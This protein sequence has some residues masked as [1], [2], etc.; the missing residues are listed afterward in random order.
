MK[1]IL[2]VRSTIYPQIMRKT[3]FRGVFVGLLGILIIIYAG[4]AIPEKTLSVWGFPLFMLGIGLLT[5]GLIPYR[6]LTRLE[7][8][9]DELIV[10]DSNDLEF[11]SKATILM[12]IPIESI[13]RVE[14]LKKNQLYGV[15]VW[16]KR[17]QSS[18]KVVFHPNFDIAAFQ[19]RADRF[20]ADLFFPY[21]SER[22]V[23]ELQE[24]IF[25]NDDL[26][27]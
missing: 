3:L 12:H 7:S 18:K 9:P 16:L 21:F 8:K 2:S 22:S 11:Y 23:K 14:Y 4:I 26:N 1:R 6:R 27:T 10:T 5:F 13:E 24:V 20:G 25:G 19:K 15:G 17:N